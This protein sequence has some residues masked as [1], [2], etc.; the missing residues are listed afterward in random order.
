MRLLFTHADLLLRGK[1]G[2]NVLKNAFLGVDGEY[3]DY[4]G[5]TRPSA[6]Y[7]EEKDMSGKLLMPGLV[8]A[9]GHSAM[10]L[11]RSA[12]S[13]LPLDRWLNEAIF[14]VEAKMTPED[15]EAG[16]TW[17]IMEML[18]S[19]TTQVA[20]MY[21][22]P[23]AGAAAY[24]KA[25]MKVNLCRVGLC[26]DPSLEPGQWGRTAE[27]INFINVMN[28]NADLNP[29]AI[30]ELPETKER[31]KLPAAIRKAV[32]AGRIQADFCLHSEYLTTEKFVNAISEANSVMKNRVHVH[33]S[34]TAKEHNECLQRHGK[35]PTAYLKDMG[36][37]DQPT[38]MA[39]CVHSTDEDFAI[40][41]E[42]GATLVHNPTSNLKLGSG[43]ARITDAINAGVNVALGTD[44]V[45]SN[46]NLDM[47]EEMHIAALLQKGA[48]KDP[49][50][51]TDTQILDMATING[52]KALGRPD[53]GVLK[54]GYK[55]DIIAVDMTA[56]H[57]QPALDPVALLV[58]SAHGSDVKMTMVDGRILYEDGK[59]TTINAAKARRALAKAV[60]HLTE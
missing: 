57:M 20:D 8:N 3:I 47:F 25:G 28:G 43:I 9:H 38:Y 35:T 60:K 58:Y 42:K 7:D 12:G 49:T 50:L 23:F 40:M 41:A 55:A 32:K 27:C 39:H 16:D 30:R 56:P 22:F 18:A 36:I 2:Y 11:V 53:T 44:G 46:N 21:D 34:E 26:F 17:A 29:E 6:A 24:A 51:L 1:R 52:A 5:K 31:G 15:I 14:P 19:G 4:I 37:L 54:T 10:T 48:R 59:F 45:A 13:G 33:V